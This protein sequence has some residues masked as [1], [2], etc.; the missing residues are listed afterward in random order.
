MTL[1]TAVLTITDW[2][3][4]LEATCDILLHAVHCTV[5]LFLWRIFDMYVG[6]CDIGSQL[7]LCHSGQHTQPVHDLWKL[8]LYT[9]GCKEMKH[10]Q[11]VLDSWKM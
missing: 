4:S 10:I 5:Q 7:A 3:A 8:W 1:V 2:L 6:S 11:L 9:L